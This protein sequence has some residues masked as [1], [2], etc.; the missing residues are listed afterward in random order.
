MI[1]AMGKT[2]LTL[3][4]FDSETHKGIKIEAVKQG[5]TIKVLVEK[6]LKEYLEAKEKQ[7]KKKGR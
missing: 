1:K 7:Q 5:L 2:T 3:K 6:I 4:D